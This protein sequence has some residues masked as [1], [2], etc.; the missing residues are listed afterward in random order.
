M[1]TKC[2]GEILR[3]RPFGNR[4]LLQDYDFKITFKVIGLEEYGGLLCHGN[5]H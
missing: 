3:E 2:S 4:S 5:E 1:P